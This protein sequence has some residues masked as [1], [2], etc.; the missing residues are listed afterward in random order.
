[1]QGRNDKARLAAEI[2]D[3]KYIDNYIEKWLNLEALINRT[4]NARYAGISVMPLSTSISWH[5]KSWS[6]IPVITAYSTYVQTAI[7]SFA[8]L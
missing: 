6:R 5:L 3:K 7:T 1:M 4:L 2:K 8:P